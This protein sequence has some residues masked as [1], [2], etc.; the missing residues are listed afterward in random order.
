MGRFVIDLSGQIFGRLTV[1]SFV[2]GQGR[3]KHAIWL[4]RCECGKQTFATS[5][6][7]RSSRTL[8]CGCLRDERRRMAVRTHG[9]S[10]WHGHSATSEYRIW[11]GIIG[12]CENPNNSRYADYG[13][14]GISVCPEWR[15]SFS[16]FLQ[17]IGRRPSPAHSLDRIESNGNYEPGNVRWATSIEQNRN[18]RSVALV[19]IDDTPLGFAAAAQ[20]LAMPIASLRKNFRAIGLIGKVA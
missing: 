6:R 15:V 17:Y 20:H 18:R 10:S 19:D 12:R 16:A 7:L 4:C 3:G 13:G 14:R 5:H 11:N 2:G 9:E 1:V 8:S